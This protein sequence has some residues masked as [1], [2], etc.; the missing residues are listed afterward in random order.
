MHEE[1]G[2]IMAFDVELSILKIDLAR[3]RGMDRL[4]GSKTASD[5]FRELA[6]ALPEADQQDTTDIQKGCQGHADDDLLG[7]MEGEE[8][9]RFQSKTA[10]GRGRDSRS[11]EK[12]GGM[13]TCW[14]IVPRD[15][16][17]G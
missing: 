5:I 7:N 3:G 1:P 2:N 15:P 12:H 8:R 11:E 4:R 9:L 16:L 17:R 10:A 6:E 13:E 14:C